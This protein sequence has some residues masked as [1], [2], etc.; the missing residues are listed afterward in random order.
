MGDQPGGKT[1]LGGG[2]QPQ[3]KT[4]LVGE[5]SLSV[6]SWFRGSCFIS[7]QDATDGSSHPCGKGHSP[8][9][10][11]QWASHTSSPVTSTHHHQGHSGADAPRRTPPS[12]SPGG[13]IR[14]RFLL[15][16]KV[17]SQALWRK[18]STPRAFL[19]QPNQ[20]GAAPQGSHLRSRQRVPRHSPMTRACRASRMQGRERSEG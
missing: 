5:T 8:E 17:S 20:P 19:T 9:N 2:D 18:V 1:S 10:T 11:T 13:H 15:G 7:S 12:F 6:V 16:E 3:G 4:S 14:G